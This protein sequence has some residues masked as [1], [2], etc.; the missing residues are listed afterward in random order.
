MKK[1]LFTCI[2]FL[3]SSITYADNY[4][5]PQTGE[6]YLAANDLPKIQKAGEVTGDKNISGFMGN[7]SS[8][9]LDI[10]DT[11]SLD[12]YTGSTDLMSKGTGGAITNSKFH[13]QETRLV[14]K[15][16]GDKLEL[17]GGAVLGGLPQELDNMRVAHETGD[18][19]TGF[20]SG[21]TGAKYNVS[22]NF[23]LVLEGQYNLTGQMDNDTDIPS[24][25]SSMQYKNSKMLKTGF[26]WNF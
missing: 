4:L 26:E 19:V 10:S 17:Y 3:L 1:N 22:K 8:N 21:R 16:W 2:L 14:K 18:V 20:V 23:G 25:F 13:T 9:K 15:V 6:Y 11:L 5:N 24:G 7:D 12:S